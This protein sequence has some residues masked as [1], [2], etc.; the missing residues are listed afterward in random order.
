LTHY[1]DTPAQ[2]GTVGTPNTVAAPAYSGF[3][4]NLVGVRVWAHTAWAVIHGG[5]QV[6][7]NVN[8]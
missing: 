3:Q 5:A 6:I 7:N 1:S 2:I 4:M 8:W